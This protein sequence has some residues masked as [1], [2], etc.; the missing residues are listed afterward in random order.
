MPLVRVES[1]RAMNARTKRSSR[2]YRTH[3]HTDTNAHT[4]THAHRIVCECVSPVTHMRRR[5]SDFNRAR[6]GED[7]IFGINR[8]PPLSQ[9]DFI[10]KERKKTKKV[11]ELSRSLRAKSSFGLFVKFGRSGRTAVMT[12]RRDQFLDFC[13]MSFDLRSSQVRPP[14]GVS[15]VSPIGEILGYGWDWISAQF[16]SSRSLQRKDKGQ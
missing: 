11:E 12:V 10:S 14:S 3:A 6:C 1:E 7:R 13:K 4:H 9:P 15:R 2:V 8:T 5:W 16:R